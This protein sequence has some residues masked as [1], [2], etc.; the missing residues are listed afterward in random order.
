MNSKLIEDF[1]FYGYKKSHAIVTNKPKLA[2]AFT[3]IIFYTNI[4]NKVP[5]VLNNYQN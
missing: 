4:G 2:Y 1:S 5:E 3:Q